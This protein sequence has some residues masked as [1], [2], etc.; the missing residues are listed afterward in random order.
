MDDHAVLEECESS[1]DAANSGYEAALKKDLPA[2]IRLSLSGNIR[3]SR[4]I[5]T[6]FVTFGI[7]HALPKIKPATAAYSNAAGAYLHCV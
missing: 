2:D 3:A 7:R 6:T 1:E 4:K 5:T